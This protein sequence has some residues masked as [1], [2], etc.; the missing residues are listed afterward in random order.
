VFY[1][2][3][4]CTAWNDA[5]VENSHTAVE[6]IM[7]FNTTLMSAVS[8][9]M[10]KILYNLYINQLTKIIYKRVLVKYKRIYLPTSVI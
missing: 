5:C 7:V 9:I 4:F 8:F 2:Q 1:Y 6:S 3:E 10:Y